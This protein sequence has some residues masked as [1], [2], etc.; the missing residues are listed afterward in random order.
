MKQLLLLLLL[1]PLGAYSQT[2]TLS[3]AQKTKAVAVAQ[4]WV[5][6][7]TKGEDIEGLLNITAVPFLWDGR[8]KLETPEQVK[9]HYSKVVTDKGKR[10]MPEI[11]ASFPDAGLKV[12]SVFKDQLVV[13]VFIPYK[14]DVED[15]WISLAE[16]NGEY[17]VSGFKD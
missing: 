13:V 6:E 16:S 11:T 1:L 2:D 17:K 5:V 8:E 3:A 10:T 7:L 4:K 15:I 14:G 12:P 9:S